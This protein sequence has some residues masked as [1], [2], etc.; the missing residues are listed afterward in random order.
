[1]KHVIKKSSKTDQYNSEKMY[2]SIYATCLAVN[3]S[4]KDA[5]NIA[6]NVTKKLEEWL[7]TKNEVTSTDLRQQAGEYL[8]QFDH[9]AGY[10]YLH[11]H[12]IW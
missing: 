8:S 2:Q 6:K 11:H 7:Q 9:H 3:T 12:I 4:K 10:L 5:I 1:M